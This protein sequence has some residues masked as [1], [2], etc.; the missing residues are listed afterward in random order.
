M[1]SKIAELRNLIRKEIKSAL[2]EDIASDIAKAKQAK[3]LATKK[4][5]DLEKKKADADVA[6]SKKQM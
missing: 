4:L 1:N 2:S 3:M 5:A 6:A